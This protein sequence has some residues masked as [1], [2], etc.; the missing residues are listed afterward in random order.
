M[1][2]LAFAIALC[3]STEA[4]IAPLADGCVVTMAA[5]CGSTTLGQLAPGDCTISTGQF[6]DVIDFAASAGQEF[7]LTLRPLA[8]AYTNPVLTVRPPS[9]D[10]TTMPI[11]IGG[12]YGAIWVRATSTGNWSVRVGTADLAARGAY[13]LHIDCVPDEAPGQPPG[14]IVQELACNQTG[15]WHLDA[16][17]CRFDDGR[18]FNQWAV[19]G[20]AGDD[21][22]LSMTSVG[23]APMFAIYDEEN[24][25]KSST[26]DGIRG[27]VMTYRI[28]RTGWYWVVPTTRSGAVG[29]SYEIEMQCNSSGCL[30]PW[31]TAA[32]A[33]VT[34]PDGG[35]T[36]TAPV[37]YYGGGT[38]T[39]QLVDASNAGTIASSQTTS[40][41]APAVT[42][43]ARVFLRA[44]NECGENNSN[45]FLLKP[46]APPRRRVVRH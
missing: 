13:A 10:G 12:D 27:A 6:G 31:F 17:S 46:D 7:A 33:D 9:G 2:R 44:I 45:V 1:R 29:G 16:N 34:V 25:L 41:H 38:F 18:P 4:Q 30:Q 15:G 28:P 19:W 22:R 26:N 43:P 42:K 32:V 11:V 37:H 8:S 20:V 35:A 5:G 40:V 24:L 23:F 14:C 3:V 36:I 21:L 39:L